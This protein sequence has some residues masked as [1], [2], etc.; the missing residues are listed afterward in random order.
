MSS[1]GWPTQDSGE[2]RICVSPWI[3]GTKGPTNTLGYPKRPTKTPGGEA[4]S[5]SKRSIIG[6][7]FIIESQR[8]KIG[9]RDLPQRS[10]APR[11]WMQRPLEMAARVS[12]SKRA[13]KA[14]IEG[15]SH[16]MLAYYLA[17]RGWERAMSIR[18][19]LSKVK[20][21]VTV[22]GVTRDMTLEEIDH[23][24]W[25]H[26]TL[27]DI[28]REAMTVDKLDLEYLEGIDDRRK[29]AMDERVK[30]LEEYTRAVMTAWKDGRVTA[31]ERLLVEQLRENLGISKG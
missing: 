9:Q 27:S 3:G 22:A 18:E 30:R 8:T 13:P 17:A 21:P 11:H 4:P 5:S 15:E 19:R 24:T 31:T 10:F 6:A 20:V 12:A 28:V 26:L 16:R 1:I 7:V 14:P 25:V 2:S 23:A 29:R